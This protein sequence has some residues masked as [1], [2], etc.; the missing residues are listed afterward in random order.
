M[1]ASV[2]GRAADALQSVRDETFDVVHLNPDVKLT[3]GDEMRD[4]HR[5]A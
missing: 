5:R 4:D 2:Q 3:T 1:K